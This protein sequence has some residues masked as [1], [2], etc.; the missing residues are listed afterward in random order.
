LAAG[1]T[2]K[3]WMVSDSSNLLKTSFPVKTRKEAVK[4][5]GIQKSTDPA[6]KGMRI[7]QKDR[8]ILKDALLTCENDETLRSSLLYYKWLGNLR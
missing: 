3:S 1:G 4:R 6:L 2:L 5:D 8:I 7:S